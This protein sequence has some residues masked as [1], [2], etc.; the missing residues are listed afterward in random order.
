MNVTRNTRQTS[1]SVIKA[2]K[3]VFNDPVKRQAIISSQMSKQP[4]F[5]DRVFQVDVIFSAFC[6][7]PSNLGKSSQEWHLS[8]QTAFFAR[9]LLS[10][11]TQPGLGQRFSE[12]SESWFPLGWSRFHSNVLFNCKTMNSTCLGYSYVGY[13]RYIYIR[14][15]FQFCTG[16]L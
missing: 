16:H 5:T 6:Q 2:A 7:R 13:V 12:I 8:L 11:S 10:R 3:R 15:L 14:I 1:A 4:R 9:S